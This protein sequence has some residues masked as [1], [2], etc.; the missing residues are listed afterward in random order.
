MFIKLSYII[1]KVVMFLSTTYCD[2]IMVITAHFLIFNIFP[3]CCT[4][5]TH[6]CYYNDLRL[7][8]MI[9]IVII[10]LFNLFEQQFLRNKCIISNVITYR[11]S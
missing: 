10:L 6:Y 5:N 4:K 2:F 7:K 11:S 1:K 3:Y 9:I 8:F